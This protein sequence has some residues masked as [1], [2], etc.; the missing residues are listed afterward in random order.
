MKSYVAIP[1]KVRL[2]FCSCGNNAV[3]LLRSN[4]Y[5]GKIV[6]WKKKGNKHERRKS[7]NSYKGKIVI[8]KEE[9]MKNE[10]TIVAIPIKVRLL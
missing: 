1:I 4:S 9:K 2:L 10:K 5:K 8:R 6:I 3:P 7:S